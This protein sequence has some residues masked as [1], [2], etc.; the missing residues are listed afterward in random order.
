MHFCCFFFSFRL[1]D[2]GTADASA[3]NSA[4]RG[5]GFFHEPVAGSVVPR[6]RGEA[7]AIGSGVRSFFF[8]VVVPF[9]ARRPYES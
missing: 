4:E 3:K 6:G 5:E 9:A 1:L 7:R 2:Y 8:L